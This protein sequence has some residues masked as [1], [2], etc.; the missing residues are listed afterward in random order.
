M[1]FGVLF[2]V[3]LMVGPVAAEAPPHADEVPLIERELLFGN[4]ERTQAR[5][6][7]DGET[8]SFLAPLDGVLN[9]WVAPAGQFGLA[10]PITSDT[11]RGI[12][13]HAWAR[14][15]THVVYQQDRGGDENYRIY[16]VEVVTGQTLDLTPFDDTRAQIT[17]ASFKHPHH[18]LIGLNNRDPRFHD[19]WRIDVRSGERTMV[20]RNDEFAGYFADHDLDLRIAYRPT[21]DGGLEMLERDGADWQPWLELP[22]EDVL[23]TNLVSFNAAGDAV[24]AVTSLERDK[25]AL[26]EIRLEDTDRAEIGASELADVSDVLVHPVTGEPLAFAA[27]Y[28]RERWSAVDDDVE[29]DLAVLRRHFAGNLHIAAQTR[30][31][32]RWIVG[33]EDAIEPLT[34]YLYDREGKLLQ[35]LFSARPDLAAQPLQPMHAQVITARDG[36]RLTSYLT[37]PPGSDPDLSGVPRQPVPLVLAVHGG[38]WARD[39]YGYNAWHQWLANRGYAVLSVNFRGSTGFGKAFIEAA[40][41][42]FAGDMHDD[43]ID[44]IDWAIANDIA[45]PRRVAI[46]GGSYGGYATLVGLTFTADRFACGVDIV[47]PSNL[48]TLIESFPPYWAPL[49]EATW[50]RRVGDPRTEEGRRQLRAASPLFRVEQIRAPLLIGQ[51]ANDPRVPERESRQIVEAMQERGLPVTYVLYP[52]EGHGFQRPEN[53]LSFYAITEAFL[54]ENCLQGRFQPI[55]GAL[56]GS[57]TRVPTGAEHVPEL[58]TALEQHEPRMAR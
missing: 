40:T 26:V 27:E 50:F 8:M 7:P 53:R 56:A 39:S 6:S 46:M 49:L 14:N 54:A 28:L 18:L 11:G 55:G 9:V 22:P 43:L 16:S 51:G 41:G 37:L 5:L 20:E 33:H 21:A 42:E 15:G 24:Y 48:L 23:T 13:M 3:I 35:A 58:D 32:Q 1:R 34:Y 36:L 44:G 57:S 47:G 25:A 4:P 45:L 12:A 29:Q 52:D 30:D 38:P 17:A 2:A 31:N 10:R 19:I